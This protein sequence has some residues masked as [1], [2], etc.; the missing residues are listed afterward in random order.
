MP[1]RSTPKRRARLQTLLDGRIAITGDG[2]L[3]SAWTLDAGGEKKG[4]NEFHL[5]WK[6]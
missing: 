4:E 1:P 6:K 5:T 2:G 3:D